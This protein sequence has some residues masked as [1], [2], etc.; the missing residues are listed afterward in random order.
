MQIIMQPKKKKMHKI[1]T[2]K[3]NWAACESFLNKAFNKTKL[4]KKKNKF[5]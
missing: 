2:N 4:Y 3:R 5:R 1:K